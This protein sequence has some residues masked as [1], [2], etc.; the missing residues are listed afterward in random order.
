MI[1]ASKKYLKQV[2]RDI[3]PEATG[4]WCIYFHANNTVCRQF[5]VVNLDIVHQRMK[6]L[7]LKYTFKEGRLIDGK[8][9]E[10]AFMVKCSDAYKLVLYHR[11]YK[12]DELLK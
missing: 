12:I 10:Y 11:S 1:G 7:R 9:K 8:I 6:Q 2:F 5:R 4:K 3:E